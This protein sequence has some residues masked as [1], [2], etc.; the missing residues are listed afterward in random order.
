[1]AFSPVSIAGMRLVPMS[2]RNFYRPLDRS[3][4]GGDENS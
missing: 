3:L 4:Y 2:G 1:M